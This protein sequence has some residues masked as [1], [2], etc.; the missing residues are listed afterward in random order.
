MSLKSKAKYNW[1]GLQRCFE[2]AVLKESVHLTTA[3]RTFRVSFRRMKAGLALV[4]SALLA[5]LTFAY[6]NGLGPLQWNGWATWSTDDI[7]GLF[8]FCNETEV[9]SV[10]DSLVSSGLKDAGY[11]LVLL[12]DCWSA[13]T[14]DANG[15][16]QPDPTRFPSGIPALVSY[17]HERG[18][19][20]GLYTSAGSEACKNGRLGSEGHFQQDA[21]WFA[22]NNVDMVKAD[23]CHADGSLTPQQIYS[24]FS[25][26]LNATGKAMAFLICEW[27]KDAPQDWA[28]AISQVYR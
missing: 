11:D 3:L 17:I 19:R 28:P 4:A 20:L 25:A 22:A 27:G 15:N 2:C 5:G 26:A 6:D 1:S 24:N 16:L 7:A 23:F 12:D 14:R 8:D 9:R 10:A 18:L 13:T 21:N